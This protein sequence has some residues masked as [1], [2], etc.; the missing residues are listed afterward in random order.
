MQLFTYKIGTMARDLFNRYIWL[1]DTIYRAGKITLEEINSKWLKSHISEGKKLSRRTFHYHR[2]AIERI[3]DIN[4]E[5]NKRGRQYYYYIDNLED[6]KK[7]K[8]RNWLLNTF[9]VNNLIDESKCIKD[10]ILFEDIP[11]G[12]E[13]LSVLIEAM[14][15]NMAVEITY[16]SFDKDMQH[17]FVIHPY[18][19]KIFKQRW[20][21][22]AFNPYYGKVM[23]YSLDRMLGARIT[24]EQ[25]AYPEDFSPKEFFRFSFGIIVAEDC[26][27][28]EV[29]LKVYG[30]H[31]K[32][33]RALPLHST[34]KEEETNKEFSTFRY[35]LRPTYD[36]VQE[37]LSHAQDMEV[38]S[39]QWLRGFAKEKI[40]EMLARYDDV[41]SQ[42]AS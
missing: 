22:A 30:N 1:A 35:F 6:L 9:T 36:F 4:I 25:F 37:I 20:Y 7:D 23:I 13:Y 10:R 21:L 34:Q 26:P 38:V 8:V 2:D 40:S 16:Q 33:I 5:C 19:V 28:E 17:T 27:A 18:C 14:R 39:P 11:S 32:Y 31:R 29:V 24:D 42:H 12:R 3:F 15:D 41:D